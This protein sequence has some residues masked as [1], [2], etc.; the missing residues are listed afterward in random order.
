MGHLPDGVRLTWLGHSTFLLEAQ[1]KRVLLEAW[2]KGN[3]VCPDELKDPG[4]LDV[5][6]V[7]HGHNDHCQDV[8]E[9]A[10]STGA[11][12]VC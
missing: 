2:L 6:L 5:I 12:V 7:T 4:P 8:V 9:L 11:T 1:G 10:K 3:P